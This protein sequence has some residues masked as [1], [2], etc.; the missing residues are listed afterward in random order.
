MFFHLS[1]SVGSGKTQAIL[2]Y[3]RDNLDAPYLYVTPT[4]VLCEEIYQRLQIVL[5]DHHDLLREGGVQLIVS[6]PNLDAVSVRASI[7]VREIE[8]NGRGVVIVTEKAFQYLLSDMD[9]ELKG[10]FKVFIDEGLPPIRS[11]EFSPGDH[12]QF[13]K[14]F[15]QDARGF[16]TAAKG[17]KGLI[18][19]VVLRPGRLHENN[20]DDLDN[21]KF[22]TICEMVHSGNYDVYLKTERKIQVVGLL[23]PMPMMAFASVTLVVAIFEQTLLPIFW[24]QKYGVEFAPFD[25]GVEL[26]DTHEAKGPSISIHHVLHERDNASKDVLQSNFETGERR[27]TDARKQVIYAAAQQINRHFPNGAFC[28]AA[29]NDF[30]NPGNVLEGDRMPAQSA[31]LDRYRRQD[32]V[33][34]LVCIN[35]Q[36]WVKTALLEIFELDDDTLYELWRLSPTYQTV[37]RC[38]LRDRNSEREVQ[39]VVISRRCAQQLSELFAG[40]RIVGQITNLPSFR[41]LRRRNKREQQNK[42]VFTPADNTAYSKYKRRCLR[43]NE[44]PLAKEFWYEQKR[45]PWLA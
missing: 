39:L 1:Q 17:C 27:E 43:K 31:G 13:L 6:D 19:D 32:T 45:K 11:V 36:P 7:A 14:Y 34:S 44:E 28:W 8:Q 38:S 24:L 5:V 30:K 25:L 22:R 42:R 9:D 35:P 12:D 41:D 3:L 33:V 40:S 15:S 21:P 16:I 4:I 23:S 18:E 10:S 2:H 37:G 26:Y 29:N 20:L